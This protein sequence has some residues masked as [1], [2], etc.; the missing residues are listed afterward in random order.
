MTINW[1]CQKYCAVIEQGQTFHRSEA[2]DKYRNYTN[3]Q[4]DKQISF[5]KKDVI[6]WPSLPRKR[7][8]YKMVAQNMLHICE[9]KQKNQLGRKQ[10]C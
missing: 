7:H 3:R 6:L 9:G 2:T 4:S 10:M 8:F 1:L 5:L